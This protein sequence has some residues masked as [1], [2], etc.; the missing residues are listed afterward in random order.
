MVQQVINVGNVAND[1]DGDPLR[2]AFEKTNLNF[3]ELYNIGGLTGIA[4]G[5]SNISI[6]EDSTIN[7]SSA[8]VANVIIVSGTG[9]TVRGTMAANIVSAS[10]NVVSSGLFLGNGALLTGVTSSAPANA[11]IG[12]TLSANVIN[13]DL[14]KS[15]CKSN[16]L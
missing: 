2:T 10:G 1:G 12:N 15:I 13:S 8:N 7:M 5:T 4:N 11:I 3:T 6:L 16:S 14:I 9:A